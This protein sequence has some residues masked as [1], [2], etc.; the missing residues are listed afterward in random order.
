MGFQE[1]FIIAL[2][3]GLIA[4]F[5][6]DKNRSLGFFMKVIT[7]AVCAVGFAVVATAIWNTAGTSELE[8]VLYCVIA[9]FVETY[10]VSWICGY[11]YGRFFM[12]E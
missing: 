2:V 6:N 12:R 7:S 4:M 9:W 3:L 10:I 5:T 8:K 1:F 11:I